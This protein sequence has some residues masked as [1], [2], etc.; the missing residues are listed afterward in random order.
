MKSIEAK[1][2]KNYLHV[3]TVYLLLDHFNS[4]FSYVL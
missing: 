2:R 4:E 1:F 3:L